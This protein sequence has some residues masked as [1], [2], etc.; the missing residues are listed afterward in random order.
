MTKYKNQRPPLS[1]FILLVHKQQRGRPNEK[2]ITN[3]QMK[4]LTIKL[5]YPT[6]LWMRRL[7]SFVCNQSTHQSVVTVS[8]N[9]KDT[10]G[11]KMTSDF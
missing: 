4:S 1:K 2:N 10:S 5:K 7:G 6:D 11:I 3:P 8:A 9:V